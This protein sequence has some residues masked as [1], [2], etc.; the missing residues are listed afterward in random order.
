MLAEGRLVAVCL[1]EKCGGT[2]IDHIEKALYSHAGAY[3]A[4]VQAFAAYYGGDCICL[5]YTSSPEPQPPASK[6][7]VCS[8]SSPPSPV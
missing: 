4:L 6:L 1:A 2:L 3:P 5:L 7:P 8:M